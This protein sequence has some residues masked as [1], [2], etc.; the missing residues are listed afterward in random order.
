MLTIPEDTPKEAHAITSGS[1]NERLIGTNIAGNSKLDSSC[2]TGHEYH[3]S[4][5][6]DVPISSYHNYLSIRADG[7]ELA[8]KQNKPVHLPVNLRQIL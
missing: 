6:T 3:S 4:S 2:T 1:R 7:D 5:F 8:S